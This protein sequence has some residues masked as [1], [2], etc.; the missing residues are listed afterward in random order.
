VTIIL[1]K[2]DY[3]RAEGMMGSARALSGILAPIFAAAL[4]GIVGLSGV[5]LIDLGTFLFAFITLAIIHVPQP[6]QTETGL[7]SKGTLWQE[8]VF[9]FRYIKVKKS[10]RAL[11]ILF[12]VAGVFLAIGATLMA[13][14][15]LGATG[16]NESAL[17]SVQSTGAVGGI[18]GAVILSL[19]GGTKR[20]IHNVLVGG[21]GACLLGIVWLGLGGAVILWAVGSFFF[22]FFEPFV[23]GGNLAI[24]QVKVP[25]D[26][27]GR[28]FSARHLLVQVPYLFGI[29]AAGYL[30]E[31]FTIPLVLI[32]AGL[33]G[34]L[35]FVLGYAVP[36]VRDAETLG[37]AI[38][39]P[40]EI[41]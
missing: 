34:A 38:P 23:E 32:G 25:A 28:V 30:A 19:W 5:M 22:A 13:P 26:V 14:L 18:V 10:L 8:I 4:L 21:V 2:E 7:Q 17:A 16:N 41:S 6:Q 20:R 40:M 24:W 31:G 29:L 1:S 39:D 37:E 33:A 36:L 12:M 9:G 11:T 35:V 15:V 27:Q 3:T